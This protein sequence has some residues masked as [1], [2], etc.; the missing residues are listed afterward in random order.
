MGNWGPEINLVYKRSYNPTFTTGMIWILTPSFGG[1]IST[2][3]FAPNA[4]RY[5]STHAAPHPHDNLPSA[6]GTNTPIKILNDVGF[7]KLPILATRSLMLSSSSWCID[8]KKR[9]IR[10]FW[11]EES[12][13]N[14]LAPTS[15]AIPL[16]AF[17]TSPE[18]FVVS[19]GGLPCMSLLI[20]K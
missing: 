20:T 9:I 18:T 6:N 8:G 17:A 12:P 5:S 11:L 15:L 13:T 14:S 1:E 19:W 16:Q 3:S 10:D 7:E 4:L 2:T